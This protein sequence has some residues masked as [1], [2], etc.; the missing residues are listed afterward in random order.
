MQK[1]HHYFSVFIFLLLVPYLC[2]L[3][4]IGLGY[5]ALVNHSA[6]LW[7]SLI[8]ALV[9]AMLMMGIKATIQRPLD[10]IAINI[11]AG[12]FKQIIRFFSIRRRPVYQAANFA[13]DFCLCLLA[14]W[15][16]RWLWSLNTIVNTATGWVLL[17]MFVST[18]LGAFIEYDNLSI[19]RT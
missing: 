2:S 5:N 10:L 8:G 14:T 17:I 11:P 16:V 15:L 7:R 1:N 12:L 13:L 18:C 19:D 3:T 6:S 4:I 9:G